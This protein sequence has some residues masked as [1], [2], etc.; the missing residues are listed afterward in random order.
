[1]KILAIGDL[2]GEISEKL[3]KN[4][5]KE[6]FDFVIGIGDYAGIED[7]M[8]WVRHVLKLKKGKNRKSP[9]EFYGKKKFKELIKKDY[10]VGKEVLLFLNHLGKPGFFIFGN[11]DE[12]DWYDYPFSKK[13][14]KAKKSRLNFLKKIRNIKEMTYKVRNYKG[15]S[16]LGFGGYMDVS[17]N[18][19]LRDRE[20]QERANNRTKKAEKRMN[21]LI[22]KL[23]KKSIF[24]LH[25]PPRGIFDKILDKKNPAYRGSSGIDFFRKAILE[26][27]PFLVLCGHM[28]EYVGKKKLGSSWVVNPGEG[29]KGKFAIIDIDEKKGKIKKIKFIN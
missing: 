10:N 24:I 29:S 3:K 2:H 13:P 4:I 25:Y 11:G 17:A 6:E 23:K 21:V 20:S 26:E 7:W 22:K 27:K 15:I 5:S 19:V 8:P 14:I 1:M 12:G 16:F 28:H 18:D 9:E